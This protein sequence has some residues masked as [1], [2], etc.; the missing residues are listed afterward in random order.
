VPDHYPYVLTLN[1]SENRGGLISPGDPDSV[2]PRVLC[3][4]VQSLRAW[5]D[6]RLGPGSRYSAGP[7]AAGLQHLP[8]DKRP[9]QEPLI[10]DNS[11]WVNYSGAQW[12][13]G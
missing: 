12:R 3:T 8:E 13:R 5:W 4:R 11:L 2:Y 10:A 1:A 9:Q 7:G 6:K